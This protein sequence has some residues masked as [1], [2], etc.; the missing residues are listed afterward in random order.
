MY[1][2]VRIGSKC[3]RYGA[4]KGAPGTSEAGSGVHRAGA[5]ARQ[6]VVAIR[7]T[8]AGIAS[9]GKDHEEGRS[10]LGGGAAS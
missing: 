10:G 7:T 4:G 8:T 1:V 5:T 3:H 6:R 9:T 2:R